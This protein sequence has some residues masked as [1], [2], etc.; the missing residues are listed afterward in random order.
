MLRGLSEP[1]TYEVTFEFRQFGSRI[2][3]KVNCI[4]SNGEH[5]EII[6]VGAGP[7]GSAAALQLANLDPNLAQRVLLMDKAIF[8][9]PK[10]C[11]GGLTKD[12][13]FIL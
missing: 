4:A 13:E 5:Y 2:T 6:V 3:G 11:A 12:A 7:S 10:I 1:L 9:R 8:P